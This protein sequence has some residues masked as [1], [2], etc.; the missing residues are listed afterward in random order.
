MGTKTTLP[1][2]N[3]IS[4]PSWQDKNSPPNEKLI[5]RESRTRLRGVE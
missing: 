1:K 5:E 3:E 2:R 4:V